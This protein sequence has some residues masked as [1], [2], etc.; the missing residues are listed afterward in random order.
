M[1]I[2]MGKENIQLCWPGRLLAPRFH[3]GLPAMAALFFSPDETVASVWSS[4][5]C[6]R[7]RLKSIKCHPSRFA[8][9]SRRRSLPSDR[10]NLQLRGCRPRP[11]TNLRRRP[12]MTQVE[13]A[14]RPRALL[15]PGLI[16]SGATLL[17]AGFASDVLYWRSLLFQWN[18][19]SGWLIAGGLVLAL[20]AAIAFVID[21]LLKRIERVSWWRFAGL[22]VAALLGLLNAFVHSRDGYT[23]VVPQGIILSAVVTVIL[24]LVGLGGGWSLASRRTALYH[25]DVRS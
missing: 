17:M 6:G 20:L 16:A 25:R 10:S 7:K 5:R 13:P 4:A 23:A 24:L 19:V 12:T 15:H 9:P 18:N 11:T 1:K 2:L 8:T 22:T 14:F 3:V 21:L